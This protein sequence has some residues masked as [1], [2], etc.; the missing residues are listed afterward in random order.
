MHL[1]ELLVCMFRSAVQT[2]PSSAAIVCNMHKDGWILLLL[3]SATFTS[4]VAARIMEVPEGYSKTWQKRD[5][6]LLM[7]IGCAMYIVHD[8]CIK[9]E[10]LC[11]I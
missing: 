11:T 2:G 5:S 7:F 6:F 3:S 8:S 9:Y 10:N 1:S 4:F